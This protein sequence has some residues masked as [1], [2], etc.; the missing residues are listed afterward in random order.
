[1]GSRVSES[2]GNSHNNRHHD[3]SS[4]VNQLDSPDNMAESDSQLTVDVMEVQDG[5]VVGRGTGHKHLIHSEL[6][7]IEIEDGSADVQ[8]MNLSEQRP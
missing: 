4:G 7:D 8:D 2:V 1:M 6:K 3:S 5:E